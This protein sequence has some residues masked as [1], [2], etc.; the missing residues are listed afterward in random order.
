MSIIIRGAHL[1]DPSVGLDEVGDVLIQDGKITSIGALEATNATTEI[2]AKGMLLC[3]SFIDLNTCLRDLNQVQKGT[4]ATETKAAASAGFTHLC[5]SPDTKPCSDD[6]SIIS[7]IKSKALAAGFCDI[8]PIAA[9]TKELNGTA[10]SNME[11][12]S[13][14]GC[15]G[16]SNAGH[17]IKDNTVLLR[18]Y[19]YAATFALKVFVQ[20]QDEALSSGHMHEGATATRMG[21][22]GIPVIA[23]T[24][25]ISRHLQFM[26]HTGV[27]G[28][29]SQISS[30]A[31][32]ELIRQAKS[33]GMQISADTSIAHLCFTDKCIEGYQSQYHVQPPLRDE[34]D[35]L[36]LIAGLKDGTLDAICS[37]HKPHESA[38]K[39][40]PFAATA[41]GMAVYDMIIPLIQTLVDAKELSWGQAINALSANSS[42]IAGIAHTTLK[43]GQPAHL[44]LIDSKHKWRL[45]E[46]SKVS[47]GTNQALAGQTLTGRVKL[48]IKSGTISFQS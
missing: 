13:R 38:A 29:F 10:L 39:C 22:E 2:N 15:I 45:D 18:C 46:A 34:S 23:E 4:I 21:L 11:S 17:D 8:L 6:G 42:A 40:A 9:L 1:L 26:Q 30:A 48:T 27:Q 20:A 3:P 41:Q 16:F 35:R 47:Q 5:P 32:V 28:H 14:A 12:L 36:A 31:G 7:L 37:A 43:T 44:T 25:A 33:Q 19:E 24:L